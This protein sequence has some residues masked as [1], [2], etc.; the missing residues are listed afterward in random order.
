MATTANATL[1]YSNTTH[2]FY[3]SQIHNSENIPSDA[4][5]ITEDEHTALFDGQSKGL[6]IT[7]PDPTGNGKP[8]LVDSRPTAT[9]VFT[10]NM[11]IFRDM[12]LRTTVDKINGVRM[13]LL[14]DTEQSQL[15]SYRQALLDVP[16]QAG[17]PNNINWPTAPS[18]LVDNQLTLLYN[19]I[20]N[21]TIESITTRGG[22]YGS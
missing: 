19:N 10:Q 2:G 7:R 20:A 13:S 4:I 15:K 1:Y 12:L 22:V 3:H 8:I 11:R 5:E 18:F 16:Q 14:S 9:T 21:T 6:T 17:F